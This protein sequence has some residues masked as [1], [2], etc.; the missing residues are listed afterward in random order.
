VEVVERELTKATTRI[1][2]V[3]KRLGVIEAKLDAGKTDARNRASNGPESSPSAS[4]ADR[5]GKTVS[6]AAPR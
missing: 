2:V 3:E 4:S 1:E 5:Q 6:G